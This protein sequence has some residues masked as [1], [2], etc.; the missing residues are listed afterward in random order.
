MRIKPEI[1]S[2]LIADMV[3]QEKT[4]NKW[5]AIGIFDR[6]GSRNFP[7]IHPSL[8]LYIRLAD[9]EGDYDI[10]VEFC[11]ASGRKLALFGGIRLSVSS[12]LISPD[13]GIQTRSLPIPKPGKYTFNLFFNNEFVQ[14]LPLIVEQIA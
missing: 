9:A 8:G 2:F 13:F 11:D 5:S 4:T 7:C 3:T 10:R 1:K 12:R 6:I 14:S